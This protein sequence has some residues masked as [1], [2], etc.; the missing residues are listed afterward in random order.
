MTHMAVEL[1]KGDRHAGN[2]SVEFCCLGSMYCGGI[3]VIEVVDARNASKVSVIRSRTSDYTLTI[4]NN[5][6]TA[7]FIEGSD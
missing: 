4:L 1:V 5:E 6:G 3:C 2:I 7:G